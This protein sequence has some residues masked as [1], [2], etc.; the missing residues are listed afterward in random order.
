MIRIVGII[1]KAGWQEIFICNL[2]HD[3][4]QYCHH[5]LFVSGVWFLCTIDIFIIFRSARTSWNTFVRSFVR[6]SVRPSARKKNL[7]HL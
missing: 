3:H 6:P 4:Y 7:N 5:Q 1:I 2:K